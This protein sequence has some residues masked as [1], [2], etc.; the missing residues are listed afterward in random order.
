MDD[1]IHRVIEPQRDSSHEEW[2]EGLLL[3]EKQDRFVWFD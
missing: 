1:C 3:E 2:V